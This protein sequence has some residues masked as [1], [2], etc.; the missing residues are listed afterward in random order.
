[1]VSSCHSGEGTE[2]LRVQ[3]SPLPPSQAVRT[4]ADKLQPR[5][6]AS[7]WKAAGARPSA[8]AR[9]WLLPIPVRQQPLQSRRWSCS[10][11]QE[12]GAPGCCCLP[13]GSNAISAL[14]APLLAPACSAP[15][16]LLQ[17][18]AAVV[19]MLVPSRAPALFCDEENCWCCTDT[20]GV[21]CCLPRNR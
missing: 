4:C 14:A 18:W 6:Q 17:S 9:G 3:T 20:A 7:A 2:T 21:G 16:R 10:S 8:A 5:P 12:Q 13:S 19:A 11:L 1:M 15:A